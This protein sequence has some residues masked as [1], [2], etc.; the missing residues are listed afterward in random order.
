M[1]EESFRQPG[2]ERASREQQSATHE[3][4]SAGA[5]REQQAAAA[6]APAAKSSASPRAREQSVVA[7]RAHSHKPSQ[8]NNLG[9]TSPET[10]TT[11][12]ESDSEL[13]P[14]RFRA[15]E[16]Q[17]GLD[18][19]V[20]QRVGAPTGVPHGASPAFILPCTAAPAKAPGD[21][22]PRIGVPGPTPTDPDLRADAPP[23][24]SEETLADVSDPFQDGIATAMDQLPPLPS[25]ADVWHLSEDTPAASV[26]SQ[27][28]T[29]PF[30][31][32]ASTLGPEEGDARAIAGAWQPSSFPGPS[33]PPRIGESR[34]ASSQTIASSYS[35]L[36]PPLDGGTQQSTV[37]ALTAQACQQSFTGTGPPQAHLEPSP[38]IGAPVRLFAPI[39]ALGP[40]PRQPTDSNV[41]A[42]CEHCQQDLPRDALMAEAIRCELCKRFTEVRPRLRPAQPP[43][44]AIETGPGPPLNAGPVLAP[45]PPSATDPGTFPALAEAT[46]S[47]SGSAL[48]SQATTSPRSAPTMPAHVGR[49]V[50]GECAWSKRGNAQYRIAV[51]AER[52]SAKQGPETAP[53]GKATGQARACWQYTEALPLGAKVIPKQP[54][55][56][57]GAK[58][59]PNAPPPPYSV[60][61]KLPPPG[62]AA[63]SGQTRLVG[64][65]AV[66][67]PKPILTL[68]PNPQSS[69]VL[70]PGPGATGP[71]A[72]SPPSHLKT[73]QATASSSGSFGAAPPHDYQVPSRQGTT[74]GGTTF[75]VHAKNPPAGLTEGRPAIATIVPHAPMP[76]RP[77]PAPPAQVDPP[78]TQAASQLIPR[79]AQLVQFGAAETVA[80]RDPTPLFNSA[81]V[82]FATLDPADPLV[83]PN[84][85]HE[86]QQLRELAKSM[87]QAP[88]QPPLPLQVTQ[89]QH[90]AP[91]ATPI[92]QAAVLA[93]S[94]A[95]PDRAST[96][97]I[98]TVSGE[99]EPHEAT[100]PADEPEEQLPPR[101]P[102]NLSGPERLAIETA[103]TADLI[104]EGGPADDIAMQHVTRH[105]DLLDRS[106]GHDRRHLRTPGAGLPQR[107]GAVPVDT[108][109]ANTETTDC[110]DV[111]I[112]PA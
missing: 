38:P 51:P 35:E 40:P 5:A 95:G 70:I 2:T 91:A 4:R 67:A 77:P 17:R 68:R 33:A 27:A 16:I 65:D 57:A 106:G 85:Q 50:E 15:P 78:A 1:S 26:A 104:E 39:A 86:M 105:P 101:L 32:L 37:H 31:D 28:T 58:T 92:D 97:P 79:I 84:L 12:D 60:P 49:I 52:T 108:T 82:Q 10:T 42:L 107:I 63:T 6:S 98:P 21:R 73:S 89:P 112:P 61:T 99:T 23:A 76:S 30:S 3:S 87:Q 24:G 96:T 25:I 11:S 56:A 71:R 9:S 103:L 44:V 47:Q 48:G 14:V 36:G 8:P 59:I 45:S 74:R 69:V 55:L 111:R 72:K 109:S 83:T 43:G 7:D 29:V 20:P 64:Q 46:A 22:I 18:A 13:G 94:F 62:F 88:P 34:P 54:P 75:G 93:Q 41:F 19:G 100:S 53:P 90:H 102:A 80:G 66:A 110:H 81:F